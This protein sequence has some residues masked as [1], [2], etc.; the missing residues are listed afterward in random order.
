MYKMYFITLNVPTY[1]LWTKILNEYFIII[2][3]NKF[4]GFKFKTIT[5]K[6]QYTPG[7]TLERTQ[8]TS[9]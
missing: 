9:G 2:Y 6:D 7:Y 3:K 8:V 1:E 5:S 4:N